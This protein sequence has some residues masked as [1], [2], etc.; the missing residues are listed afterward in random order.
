MIRVWPI[1][2]IS[3]TKDVHLFVEWSL[4]APVR[5]L[6]AQTKRKASLMSPSVARNCELELNARPR[7]PNEC[8]VRTVSG[9]SRG[10]SFAVEKIRTRG[11]YPVCGQ[12][13]LEH[14]RV[15]INHFQ[16]LTSPTARNLPLGLIATLVTALILSLD[17]HV[18]EPVESAQ[19]EGEPP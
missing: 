7:T 3:R 13:S 8:S 17:V 16:I 10:A 15:Y 12:V 4:A 2:H 18:L 19:S 11:L 5:R 14:F 1:Q 6:I 9:T